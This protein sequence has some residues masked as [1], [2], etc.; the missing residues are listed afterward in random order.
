MEGLLVGFRKAA[1]GETRREGRASWLDR[2]GRDRWPVGPS[3]CFSLLCH[4]VSSTL[5]CALCSACR[6]TGLVLP[7]KLI[8]CYWV[9]F[10]LLLCLPMGST[11]PQPGG[12]WVQAG[13]SPLLAL[14]S[15]CP[16]NI[17]S[18]QQGFLISSPSTQ[19]PPWI[20]FKFQHQMNKKTIHCQ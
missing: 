4:C 1:A 15:L 17:S 19:K 12:Q 14:S 8:L 2:T 13:A 9:C 3:R 20:T 7:T 6:C 18:W 16:H 5:Q 10:A 11:P